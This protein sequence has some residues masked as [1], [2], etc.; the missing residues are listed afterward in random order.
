M[1]LQR[2]TE[3]KARQPETKLGA[4]AQTRHTARPR[5]TK[6]S[7][8]KHPQPNPQTGRKTGLDNL[9]R[10]PS[11]TTHRGLASGTRRDVSARPTQGRVAPAKGNA[12]L[13]EHPGMKVA[14]ERPG[15]PACT[16]M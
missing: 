9:S 13:A 7:R 2:E 14:Q 3:E 1:C 12:K 11:E 16:N 8:A 6:R 15:P 10:G 5:N 4:I